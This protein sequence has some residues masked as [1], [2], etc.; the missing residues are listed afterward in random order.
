MT[1]SAT[2][3]SPPSTAL[4][5][6]RRHLRRATRH[7]HACAARHP[8]RAGRAD[9]RAAR[10]TTAL[11]KL[12]TFSDT[13]TRLSQRQPD[14]PGRPTSTTSN[15]RCV[16]SPT[17]GPNLDAA[18]AYVPVFP[19]GQDV[20]DRA[21][22]ATTSTSTPSST[23]PSPGSNERCSRHPLGQTRRHPGARTRGALLPQLQ[24]TTPWALRLPL[25]GRPAD[26][27][28]PLPPVRIRHLCPPAD[29]RNP[30][31]HRTHRHRQ[32]G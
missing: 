4:E 13:A 2:T 25:T 26:P 22:A 30:L 24:P 27:S 29:P 19:F 14:R 5:P 18:L 3:S 8:T 23:S 16:R 15:R 31:T 20:I 32:G 6:T 10:I 7:H 21:S 12:G 28:R 9:P 1:A 11:D 17:S